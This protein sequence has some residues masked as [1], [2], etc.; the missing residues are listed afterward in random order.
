MT[1]KSGTTIYHHVRGAKKKK[2][3]SKFKKKLN[4]L[5][6]VKK[7]LLLLQRYILIQDRYLKKKQPFSS[8]TRTKY[9]A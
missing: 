6:D 5:Y 2:V 9:L 1:I 8:L 7:L 3:I 4:Q